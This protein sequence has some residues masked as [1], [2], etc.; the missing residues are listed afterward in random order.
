M[1]E[2]MIENYNILHHTHDCI[3]AEDI[4]SGRYNCI[5]SNA[6]YYDSLQKSKYLSEFSSPEARQKVLDNLGISGLLSN[7]VHMRG[8]VDTL[9]V[10]G[11]SVGDMYI[12]DDI[13]YVA[14]D[15]GIHTVRWYTFDQN[16]KWQ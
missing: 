11:V 3:N 10:D 1:S 13:A 6:Q 15:T 4:H 2:I 5:T 7:V 16:I 12:C 8:C 14:I 9:P